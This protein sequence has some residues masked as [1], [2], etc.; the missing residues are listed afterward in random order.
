M[1]PGSSSR[2]RN[3]SVYSTV[4]SMAEL[5]EKKEADSRLLQSQPISFID[6]AFARSDPRDLSVTYMASFMKAW[7]EVGSGGVDRTRVIQSMRAR[8]RWSVVAG[9]DVSWG[10]GAQLRKIMKITPL[11]LK[12]VVLLS[13][14]PTWAH[15]KAKATDELVSSTALAEEVRTSEEYRA[16]VQAYGQGTAMYVEVVDGDMAAQVTNTAFDHLLDGRGKMES[17]VLIHRMMPMLLL[18]QLVA[19]E[20]RES[21]YDGVMCFF[22]PS[23]EPKST[24]F[25]KLFAGSG[26]IRLCIVSFRTV[27]IGHWRGSLLLVELAP[28]SRSLT[29][30]PKRNQIVDSFRAPRSCSLSSL[31]PSFGR[32]APLPYFSSQSLAPLS[33]EEEQQHMGKMWGE[34]AEERRQEAWQRATTMQGD[35]A[36]VNAST[37]EEGGGVGERGRRRE[38]GGREEERRTA[39]V[40]AFPGLACITLSAN[41]NQMR[42]LLKGAVERQSLFVTGRAPTS[43][44]QQAFGPGNSA[45]GKGARGKLGRTVDLQRRKQ[46]ERDSKDLAASNSGETTGVVGEEDDELDAVLANAVGPG[47]DDVVMS[48]VLNDC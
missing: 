46:E 13:W 15:Q 4:S 2:S 26:D 11:D 27:Q 7:Q 38:E 17:R 40:Y 48:Q 24:F 10:I 36:E 42:G 8:Q 44:H 16:L 21:F 41:E 31:S 5:E 20:D 30:Q 47:L 1:I 9:C 6:L 14:G 12:D 39:G 33:V 29:T 37:A 18:G 43:L 34:H 19:P 45:D 3:E 25:L 35:G 23:R 28:D 32:R 22:V